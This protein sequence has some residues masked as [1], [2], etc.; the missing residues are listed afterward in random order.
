MSKWTEPTRSRATGLL[1]ALTLAAAGCRNPFNPSCDIELAEFKAD[2]YADE[3][4]IYPSQL[5]GG[6][7]LQIANWR[8]TAT[9][10]IRNKVAATLTSVNIVYTDLDGTEVTTYKTSGGKSFKVNLRLAPMSDNNNP[11]GGSGHQEGSGSTVTLYM[12]DRQVINEITAPGYQPGNKFMYATVTFRGED[13]N[14]YDFKLV[15]K[16]GIKYY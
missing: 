3:I 5:S 11:G 10:V 9:M 4:I 8:A 13:D 1:L 6:G 7:N 14:G 12:V 15:G 16:I 2:S